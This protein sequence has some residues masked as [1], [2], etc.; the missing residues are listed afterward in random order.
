MLRS[1]LYSEAIH[2]DEDRNFFILVLIT[3]LPLIKE[4]T[5]AKLPRIYFS[6]LIPVTAKSSR[7]IYSY[8][9]KLGTL[10][11]PRHLLYP[12]S[13]ITALIG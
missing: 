3:Y 11:R 13:C 10:E 9:Y 4:V 8:Y 2:N 1:A 5:Y 6:A 12:Y 7:E